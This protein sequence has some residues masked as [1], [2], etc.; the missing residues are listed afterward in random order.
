MTDAPPTP[1]PSDESQDGARLVPVGESIKYR[2]RAQQAEARATEVEQ[3][4]TDLQAQ[5]ERRSEEL[6]EAEAQRDEARHQL[7][8]AE[9]RL[10][11]ERK[12]TQAGVVDVETASLLLAR[13][14]DLDGDLDAEELD[15][16]IEEL[17]LEKPFLRDRTGGG[18]LPPGTAAAREPAEAPAA[19]LA[20]AA[21]RAAST[22]GR[23][24]VAD[25]LR[26]RRQAAG[27]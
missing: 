24:D 9:N 15:R 16:R 1:E 23:R 22:G 14:A 6:A 27:R 25:Y 7:Q 26:L 21:Q 11:A 3:Q 2:R 17:L 10:A 18:S 8:A 19:R 4:L 5:Q 12:L 20:D 13:R